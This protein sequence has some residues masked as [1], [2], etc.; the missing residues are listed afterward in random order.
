MYLDIRDCTLLRPSFI[1]QNRGPLNR[2]ILCYLQK[3]LIDSTNGKAPPPTFTLSGLKSG[4]PLS[5]IIEDLLLSVPII[6]IIASFSGIDGMLG[7]FDI[8]WS[9][10]E[11]CLHVRSGKTSK[12]ISTTE[13][14]KWLDVW[15][16]KKLT[17][18]NLIDWLGGQRHAGGRDI[19]NYGSILKENIVLTPRIVSSFLRW[20]Q[21]QT[22]K[23]A[24][25]GRTEKSLGLTL[26]RLL[27]RSSAFRS[28]GSPTFSKVLGVQPREER[29]DGGLVDASPDGGTSSELFLDPATFPRPSAAFSGP[30]PAFSGKSPFSS[31]ISSSSSSSS[32]PCC[33]FA[34]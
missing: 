31:S 9:Y 23:K 19:F 1:E 29:L 24:E 10:A 25:K 12:A 5:D 32:S 7:R 3:S 21:P 26:L 15:S 13:H 20:H 16:L 11:F 30:F 2:S 8:I 28:T 6:I 17:F 33:Y 4:Q 14:G 34:S 18:L 22:V 27:F